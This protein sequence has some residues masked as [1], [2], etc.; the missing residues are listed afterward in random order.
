[1]ALIDWDDSLSVKVE[2]IDQEHQKL[3]AMI[4]NLN[5]AMKNGRGRAVIGDIVRELSYY[6]REHFR[7][8]EMFFDMHAYPDAARHRAEHAAFVE[9]VRD[10]EEGYVAAR[11]SLSVEVMNFL[12]GWVKNHIRGSDLRYSQFFIDH[13]VR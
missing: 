6:A 2:R 1:M 10:F 3:L 7:T 9:Q 11:L 5:E 8:E 4:N 13:G 12:S